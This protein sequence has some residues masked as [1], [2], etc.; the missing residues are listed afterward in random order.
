M[1]DVKGGGSLDQR[2]GGEKTN[3]IFFVVELTLHKI[4]LRR[5]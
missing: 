3:E 2:I 1:V 5:K 4:R